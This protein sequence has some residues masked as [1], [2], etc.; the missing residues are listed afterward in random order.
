M[1]S[2]DRWLRIGVSFVYKMPFWGM[3][4]WP[5]IGG[6]LLTTVAAIAGFTLLHLISILTGPVCI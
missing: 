4:E 6:W 3:A 5:P 1:T 2:Q